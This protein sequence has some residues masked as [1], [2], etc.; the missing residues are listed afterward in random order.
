MIKVAVRIETVP[1][2]PPRNCVRLDVREGEFTVC[3]IVL[4][5]VPLEPFVEDGSICVVLVFGA[6]VIDCRTVEGKPL[7]T[8]MYVMDRECSNTGQKDW[9]SAHC[10]DYWYTEQRREG[11]TTYA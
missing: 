11:E 8:P 3:G 9:M 10:D 1:S 5:I 7:G 4:G 6:V 2:V